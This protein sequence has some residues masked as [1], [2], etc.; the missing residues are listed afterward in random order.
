M[1]VINVFFLIT[2]DSFYQPTLLLLPRHIKAGNYH[3][4]FLSVI[5]YIRSFVAHLPHGA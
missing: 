3:N 4:R 1:N 2:N 5:I